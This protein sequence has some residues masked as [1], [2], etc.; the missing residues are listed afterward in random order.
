MPEGVIE[1][2]YTLFLL[3]EEESGVGNFYSNQNVHSK[4]LRR[5]I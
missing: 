1:V 3:P 4:N 5:T 2:A